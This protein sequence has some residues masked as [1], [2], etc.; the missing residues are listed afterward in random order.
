MIQRVALLCVAIAV[1]ACAPKA[2]TSTAAPSVASNDPV[3][4]ASFSLDARAAASEGYTQ[5]GRYRLTDSALV[6]STVRDSIYRFTNGSPATISVIRYDVPEHA[7]ISADS[8]SWTTTEGELFEQ[9]QA[10]LMQQGRIQAFQ[11]TFSTTTDVAVDSAVLREHAIAIAV[12]AGGAVRV[13][14]QYLY[15]VG[16]RFLK[17][18]GTFPGDSWETTDLEEFAREVARRTYRATARRPM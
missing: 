6:R 17:V 5:V 12:R 13:D 8:Q 18:R 7:K 3:S 2:S 1:S 4:R 11:K 10:T 15:L 9:V 14:F 16:G